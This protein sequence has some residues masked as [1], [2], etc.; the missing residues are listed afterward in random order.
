MQTEDCSGALHPDIRAGDG[1]ERRIDA[2]L[3][4][5]NPQIEIFGEE[6]QAKLRALREAS[7]EQ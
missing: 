5:G 1:M 7:Q 2:P 3:F 6:W 4:C